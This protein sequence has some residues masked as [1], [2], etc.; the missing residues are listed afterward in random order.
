MA[1]TAVTH[2]RDPIWQTILPA[3]MEHLLLGAIPKEAYMLGV[4][5]QT[6][7][8]VSAVHLTPGGA[9][10]YHAVVQIHKGLEGEA[11]EAALAAFAAHFDVKQ[12]VVVDDDVNI[13]DPQEV[14]WAVA[15]RVQAD[16]D[17]FFVPGGARPSANPSV[18][19]GSGT[20]MG[21]D[22]TVPADSRAG[23]DGEIGAFERIRIPDAASVRLEEYL[24]AE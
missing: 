5:R 3:G 24:D 11:R 19:H 8:T 22:A 10:R 17:I 9:C 2:R 21:I 1:I 4:V 6:V 20:K 7:P 13:F 16:R 15:T 12:V 18:V 23:Q 14:E